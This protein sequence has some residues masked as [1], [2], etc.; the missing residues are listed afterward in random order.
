MTTTPSGN[1]ILRLPAGLALLTT[2]VLATGCGAPETPDYEVDAPPPALPGTEITEA[3]VALA[4][5]RGSGVSGEASA[6]HSEDEV[7]VVLQVQGLP[8]AGQYAAHIH[9]GTC[10]DG[11]PV[12]VPLNAVVAGEDGEGT[13]STTLD[14]GDMDHDQ[15]HFFQVHSADGPPVACGDME[16]DAGME[17]R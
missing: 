2:L 16:V 9:A 11:G 10:A 1:P 14:P 13:S 17:P 3:T 12:A 4:P 15:S 5:V 8:R 6:L 7:V